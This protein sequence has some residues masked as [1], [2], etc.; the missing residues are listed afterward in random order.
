MPAYLAS[1]SLDTLTGRL[2]SSHVLDRTQRRCQRWLWETAEKVLQLPSS[3]AIFGQLRAE[4]GAQ[5]GFF[6]ALLGAT[7]IRRRQ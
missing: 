4:D 6:R 5:S 1:C 3:A 7:V 2:P